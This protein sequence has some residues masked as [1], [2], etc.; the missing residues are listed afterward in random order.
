MSS[1]DKTNSLIKINDENLIEH[2]ARVTSNDLYT[3]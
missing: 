1:D 2:P 3:G